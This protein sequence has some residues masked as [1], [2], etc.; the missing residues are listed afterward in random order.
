MQRLLA[1]SCRTSA[2]WE[3]SRSDVAPS[4]QTSFRFRHHCNWPGPP[5]PRRD[6]PRARRTTSPRTPDLRCFV[7]KTP[8]QTAHDRIVIEF[9][10]VSSPRDRPAEKPRGTVADCAGNLRSRNMDLCLEPALPWSKRGHD[11]GRMLSRRQRPLGEGKPMWPGSLQV[12]AWCDVM[13]KR[14]FRGLSAT[15]HPNDHPCTSTTESHIV[16]DDPATIERV[17]RAASFGHRGDGRVGQPRTRS[18][19][20]LARSSLG[21]LGI[22]V[23][24]PSAPRTTA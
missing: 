22:S 1:D 23:A 11:D 21:P 10:Q 14:S 9:T 18:H 7:R 5:T 16:D 12:K 19:T 15:A 17:S 13:N 20:R 2:T 6:P 4:S 24:E 3:S 8:L